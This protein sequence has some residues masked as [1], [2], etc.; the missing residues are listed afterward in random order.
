MSEDRECRETPTASEERWWAKLERLCQSR[1]ASLALF[2]DGSLHGVDAAQLR[3]WEGGKMS[4][5]VACPWKGVGAAKARCKEGGPGLVC[6]CRGT[7]GT[8]VPVVASSILSP[9][10]GNGVEVRR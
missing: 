1:P 10:W 7:A 3:R 5:T 9:E 4:I 8:T 2:A 6:E